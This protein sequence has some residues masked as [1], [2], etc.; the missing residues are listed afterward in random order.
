MSILH[1]CPLT[2]VNVLY[3]SGKVLGAIQSSRIGSGLKPAAASTGAKV[4]TDLRRVLATSREEK[5]SSTSTSDSSKT[6]KRT[7]KG[8]APV[9]SCEAGKENARQR[10][11]KNGSKQSQASRPSTTE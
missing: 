4:N 10:G 3:Y 8:L 7:K 1:V 5:V 11:D 6:T 9:A 2:Y